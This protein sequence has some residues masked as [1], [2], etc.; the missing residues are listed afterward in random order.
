MCVCRGWGDGG[1]ER[2][3]EAYVSLL[4]TILSSEQSQFIRYSDFRYFMSS[5]F[6]RATYIEFIKPFMKQGSIL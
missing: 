2:G 1:L 4:N 6:Q 5:L 3:L